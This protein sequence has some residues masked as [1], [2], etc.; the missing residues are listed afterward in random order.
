MKSFIKKV[1][2]F[3]VLLIIIDFLSGILLRALVK[4]AKGGD[5]A[6]NEY[7]INQV[8]D[9]ILIFGSSRGMCSYNP[10]IISKRLGESCYNCANDGMGII[11]FWN[12]FQMIRDRY[13][14]KLIIYDVWADFDLK[15]NADV[16]MNLDALRLYYDHP[17]VK[18]SF[19]QIAPKERYKMQSN[20][21]RYSG[22][23]LQII[24]DNIYPQNGDDRGYRPKYGYMNYEPKADGGYSKPL[25]DK[26]KILYLGELIRQCKR[27]N[28]QIVFCI[29]PFY[30]GIKHVEDM[31]SPLLYLC[32]LYNIPFWDFSSDKQ[33][34]F[35]KYYFVD[36]FHLNAE[37]AAI[38]SRKIAEK[39][40]RLENERK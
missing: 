2:V 23:V 3:F 33:L 37:G 35:N 11:L 38:Y 32:K 18:E 16:L 28:I 34:A 19:Q 29:S 6:R 39:L 30:G 13:A 4:N 12:R 31:Y 36:S 17:E 14:P 24:A 7:I 1:F 9:S 26:R 25:Y 22:K 27:N 10:E 15:E 8:Q 21:Y 5:T 40:E 20:L